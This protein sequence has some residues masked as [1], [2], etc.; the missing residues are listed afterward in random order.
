MTTARVNAVFFAIFLSVLAAIHRQL[1]GPSAET[2][3]QTFD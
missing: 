1:A 2:V 3:S